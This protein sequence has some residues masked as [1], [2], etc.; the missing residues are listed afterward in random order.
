MRFIALLFIAPLSLWAQPSEDNVVF[1]WAFGAM[2]GPA[3]SFVTVSRD[4]V[5]KTGDEVKM[6]VEVKANCF[7]YVVYRDSKGNL[8][9]LFPATLKSFS[10]D[11]EMKK[12]YYIP[13]GRAWAKFDEN[14]GQERFY[15]LA[16]ATR[17]TELENLLAQYDAAPADRKSLAADN[18]VNE[19]RDMRRRFK[20]FATTA[21]K[22]ISIGGNVRGVERS[23]QVKYPDVAQ[24]ATEIRAVNF[25]SKTFTIDHR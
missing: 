22:P 23:V 5:L 8:S 19:I 18:I 1:N 3:K 14:T 20:T 4:T 25:Y 12:N 21:E 11:Y 15:L 2:V 16:S 7:V 17:L 6:M 10:T 9:L 13:P 24:F